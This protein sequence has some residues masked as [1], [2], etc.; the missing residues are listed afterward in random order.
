MISLPVLKRLWKITQPEWEGKHIAKHPPHRV[1]IGDIVRV[2]AF[3]V[4]KKNTH[5]FR[6][7]A[8]S[9]SFNCFNVIFA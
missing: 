4:K 3:F 8:D 7:F 6:S 2:S 9:Y 1:D 5:M